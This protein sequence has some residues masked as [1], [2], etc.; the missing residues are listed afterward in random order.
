MAWAPRNPFSLEKASTAA[1]RG[2]KSP[3]KKC[4]SLVGTARSKGAKG[5]Q[6]RFRKSGRVPEMTDN[7]LFP[8]RATDRATE[9]AR[10]L[11]DQER[12]APGGVPGGS[13]GSDIAVGIRWKQ[14][15]REAQENPPSRCD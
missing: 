1:G 14:R 4:A 6:G 11:G 10:R 15:R 8:V 3:V 2:A 5:R 13:S 7:I 12:G 9:R